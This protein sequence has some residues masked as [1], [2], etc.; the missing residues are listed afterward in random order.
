[1]L[2]E[3]AVRSYAEPAFE[4]H[5]VRRPQREARLRLPGNQAIASLTPLDLLDV[6]WRSLNSNEEDARELQNLAR[7]VI[8]SV[9]GMSEAVETQTS[10]VFDFPK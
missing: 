2:N 7:E 10:P 1:M 3:Q 6:Y 4:F 8:A 9:S 5:L